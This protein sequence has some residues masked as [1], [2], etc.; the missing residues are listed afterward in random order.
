MCIVVALHRGQPAASTILRGSDF[1]F[2]LA[3]A[4][5]TNELHLGD[6]SAVLALE[7]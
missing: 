1:R 5:G 3:P 4:I 2:D 7:E 6:P